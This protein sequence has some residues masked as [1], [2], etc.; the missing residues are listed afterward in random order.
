MK[1]IITFLVALLFVAPTFAQLDTLRV[2]ELYVGATGNQSRA[3]RESDTID[4]A[5]TVW[6]QSKTTLAINNTFATNFMG[7]SLGITNSGTSTTSMA[8]GRV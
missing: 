4:F 5:S 8:D 3:L 6:E 2:K 7:K 1:R